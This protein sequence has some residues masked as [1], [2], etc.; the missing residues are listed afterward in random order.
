MSNSDRAIG[1]AEC[2][3]ARCYDVLKNYENNQDL[4][5]QILQALANFGKIYEQPK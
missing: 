1:Y 4:R 5:E 2:V 3:L